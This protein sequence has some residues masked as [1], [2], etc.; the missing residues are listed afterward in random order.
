MGESRPVVLVAD[1]DPSVCDLLKEF[2]EEE[3]YAVT[4]VRSGVA[5]LAQIET[6]ADDLA[7]LDWRLP[8]ESGPSVCRR[9][10]E[11]VPRPM[12]VMHTGLDD[13]RDRDAARKAGA[14]EFLVK[15][16]DPDGLADRLRGLLGGAR[17]SRATQPADQHI[18]H[19]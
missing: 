4:C 12:I 13:P 7:L 16:V 14:D 18:P 15:G 5:A 17:F 3:G 1:D 9:L 10:N 2:L 8:D 11:S 6:Y 19:G